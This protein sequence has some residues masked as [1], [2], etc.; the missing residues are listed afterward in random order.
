MK[1]PQRTGRYKVEHFGRLLVKRN[2][3]HVKSTGN[4]CFSYPSAE[5]R[6]QSFFTVIF[7]IKNTAHI[8]S[9]FI[10]CHIGH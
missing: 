7:Y 1:S 5:S 4:L 9:G 3:P 2:S 10:W 8:M 6:N